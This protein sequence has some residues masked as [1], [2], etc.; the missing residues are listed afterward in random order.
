L[1]VSFREL[2]SPLPTSKPTEPVEHPTGNPSI[3]EISMQ[4]TALLLRG[5]ASLILSL[6]W[7]GTVRFLY[8]AD[9]PVKHVILYKH[10]VAFFER[11]GSFQAG[12]NIR[13]EFQNN[14]MNDVLKSLTVT[15]SSGGRITAVR[16]DSNET[17]EQRLQK[18]PS[19]S[20]IRNSSAPF[21]ID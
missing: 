3:K 1:S 13:L 18:F 21:S 19:S 7:S 16:Y 15:D 14:E 17:P 8:P 4:R 9:M 10:G 2:F 5:S 6:L 12:Q 11:E 20:M